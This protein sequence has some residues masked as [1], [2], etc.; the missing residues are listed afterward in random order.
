M[1]KR[2]ILFLNRT[3]RFHFCVALRKYLDQTGS[4]LTLHVTHEERNS[5]M[6]ELQMQ[7]GIEFHQIPKV[8]APEYVHWTFNFCRA[9]RVAFILVSGD[10][11]LLHLASLKPALEEI[12][13]RL[14]IGPQQ[15]LMALLDKASYEH[16][17]A[18]ETWS[19]PR[20][21]VIDYSSLESY[22]SH[23][24][25]LPYLVKPRNGISSKDTEIV[26][27]EH[28]LRTVLD[29]GPDFLLQQFI[30]GDAYTVDVLMSDD[31]SEVCAGV[32][33]R[34]LVAGAHSVCT[35]A[36]SDERLIMTAEKFAKTLK[37]PGIWSF[38]FIKCA[39]SGKI[40]IHDVNPRMANGLMHSILRGMPVFEWIAA[41]S[42]G[43]HVSLNGGLLKGGITMKICQ[44][45]VVAA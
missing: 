18:G 9:N 14:T 4:L 12:G 11:D 21:K 34:D 36:V 8:N 32:R 7:R 29:K 19:V 5:C 28:Q 22:Q 17:L 40:Y 3:D 15:L 42:D 2:G 38:Q 24:G 44:E 45:Y 16:V 39:T 27:S 23:L 26:R 6:A 30:T 13:T 41:Q 43:K 25:T 20:A 1:P 35:S 10:H 31:A 37:L 33:R